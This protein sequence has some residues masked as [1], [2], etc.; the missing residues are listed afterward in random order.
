MASSGIFSVPL[1]PPVAP[2]T[3]T[4]ARDLLCS[5]RC[6]S[7]DASGW[8]TLFEELQQFLLGECGAL[9]AGAA[10][11][12]DRLRRVSVLV[13][14]FCRRSRQLAATLHGD[15]DSAKPL[16]V[17]QARRVR[18]AKAYVD[19]LLRLLDRAVAATAHYSEAPPRLSSNSRGRPSA[20]VPLP[21]SVL[22]SS[23]S[24]H[25]HRGGAGVLGGSPCIAAVAYGRGEAVD[26]YHLL[27]RRARERLGS[28]LNA[29]VLWEA[30]TVLEALLDLSCFPEEQWAPPKPWATAEGTDAGP[31]VAGCR[32]P[33]RDPLTQSVILYPCR[34]RRCEHF[35]M[36]D[37]KNFL[38]CFRDSRAFQRDGGRAPGR[39]CP[40]C[41]KALRVEDLRL[42]ER[43]LCAVAAYCAPTGG[44]MAELT[45][46]EAVEWDLQTGLDPVTC[47]V[48]GAAGRH[49]DVPT[50]LACAETADAPQ[51]SGEKRERVSE[52]PAAG[53]DKRRRVEQRGVGSHSSDS[54]CDAQETGTTD[55]RPSSRRQV[56]D[57]G[58]LLCFIS[59]CSLFSASAIRLDDLLSLPL[60]YLFSLVF[61]FPVG[62]DCTSFSTNYR[63]LPAVVYSLYECTA[64]TITSRLT[65]FTSTILSHSLVSSELV[66]RLRFIVS[67]FVCSVP[68]PLPPLRLAMIKSVSLKEFSTTP[69]VSYMLSKNGQNLAPPAEQ[70]PPSSAPPPS[71]ERVK[72]SQQPSAE[73]DDI[74]ALHKFIQRRRYTLIHTRCPFGEQTGRGSLHLYLYHPLEPPISPR[75]SDAH[76]SPSKYKRQEKCDFNELYTL[77]LSA[78]LLSAVAS[79]SCSFL[80]LSLSPPS[81][82]YTHI[83][84]RFIFAVHQIVVFYS[85]IANQPQTTSS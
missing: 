82:L 68:P 65:S 22:S 53:K 13:A 8:R 46:E 11:P 23:S 71:R 29:S 3:S 50:R 69:T 80:C 4:A 26:Y 39:P 79:F 7:L 38:L 35:E 72:V 62:L 83:L 42:D 16:E 77:S 10:Q 61:F 66:L 64:L 5:I 25:N 37:A 63:S 41:N 75:C 24:S 36:F 48:V 54:V 74:E 19:A 15:T 32:S 1:T 17:F 18:V 44:E 57:I 14:A 78:L 43:V 12:L 51:H 6:R 30:D 34:G 58:V 55:R 60:L 33:L 47:R 40:H 70:H 20:G 67:F 27:H 56:V 73:E 85:L 2:A 9:E 45:G 31:L 52:E 76:F 59:V 28:I 84:K 81:E 49:A 21:L